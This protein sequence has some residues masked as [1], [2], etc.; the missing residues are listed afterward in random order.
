MDVK[1]LAI[2]ASFHFEFAMMG[3]FQDFHHDTTSPATTI[4]RPG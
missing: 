4:S 3:A 2:A 1:L